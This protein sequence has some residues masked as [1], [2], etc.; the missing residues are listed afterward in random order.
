MCLRIRQFKIRE[1]LN[2]LEEEFIPIGRSRGH[3]LGPATK[4]HV[5]DEVDL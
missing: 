4:N 1:T 5:T 2:L 3:G